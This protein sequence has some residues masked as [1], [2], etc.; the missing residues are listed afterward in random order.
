M[1]YPREIS[2]TELSREIHKLNDS[3]FAPIIEHYWHNYSFNKGNF[4]KIK[5]GLGYVI[6]TE[7]YMIMSTSSVVNSI[8]TTI[9]IDAE[10]IPAY[11]V[12]ELG[13][14]IRTATSDY[15]DITEL[16]NSAIHYNEVDERAKILIN[17]LKRKKHE[18]Y[19]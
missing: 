6:D 19:K 2:S 10:E 15:K 16:K 7:S 17:I 4:S 12:E 1:I 8:V 14:L 13:Y 18:P 9:P 3:Y 5:T 11:T